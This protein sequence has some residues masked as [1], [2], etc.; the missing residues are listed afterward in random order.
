MKVIIAPDS[1]K[2]SLSAVEVASGI[3]K[4]VRNAFSHAET[5]LLP[6]AD[7]GEGTMET[8]IAATNGKVKEVKVTGPLG[9]SVKAMYGVLG[10]GETCVIEVAS[11]SGL[12]L[13]PADQLNPLKTTTYGTGE[14]IKAA[15]DDGF[16]SFIFALGGSA[17][18]DGG[19]GMLQA[20]GAR[21]LD[22]KKEDISYGGGQLARIRTIDLTSF[23]ARLAHC[24]ILIASVMYKIHLLEK[25]VLQRFLVHKKGQ[26]LRW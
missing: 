1:F 3:N 15:L 6:V 23:D 21:L 11:A 8:L 13:V 7:G 16:R 10:N 20:L 14:L 12:A 5:H 18:N 2:G 4:G 9:D 19:A 17:T 25:T 24:K 22:E 26:L